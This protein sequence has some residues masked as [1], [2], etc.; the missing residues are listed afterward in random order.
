MKVVKKNTVYTPVDIVKVSITSF[1]N[2]KECKETVYSVLSDL[3]RGQIAYG[4]DLTTKAVALKYKP[5]IIN[6]E[7]FSLIIS[8]DN[9]Y[10]YF[11]VEERENKFVVVE[12]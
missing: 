7:S 12:E 6:V 9:E 3:T 4:I 8:K 2:E 10:L 11:E 5:R 1:F